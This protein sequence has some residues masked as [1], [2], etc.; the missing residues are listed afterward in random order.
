MIKATGFTR[1]ID[2]L[3][4]VIIPKPLIEKLEIFKKISILNGG[5][6]VDIDEDDPESFFIRRSHEIDTIQKTVVI[7]ELQRLKIPEY[8]FQKLCFNQ[9]TFIEFYDCGDYIKLKPIIENK[10]SDL[11]KFLESRQYGIL[12]TKN[13]TTVQNFKTPE[14][15]LNF[16]NKNDSEIKREIEVAQEING[17][18]AFLV[19]FKYYTLYS[20]IYVIE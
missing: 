20:D 7:D 11:E 8:I 14:A 4:R 12:V 16:I 19:I 18:K 10:K 9:D 1:K 5:V 13:G 17:G 15:A 2:D 3:G 6:Y